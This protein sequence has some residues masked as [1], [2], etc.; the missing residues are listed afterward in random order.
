MARNTDNITGIETIVK[1]E[2]QEG[3]FLK[4]INYNK[5]ERNA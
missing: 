3:S 4:K 5:E 1:N 2:L